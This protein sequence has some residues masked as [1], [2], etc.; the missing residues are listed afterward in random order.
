MN[1]CI[2]S[3]NSY[4]FPNKLIFYAISG[5]ILVTRWIT[6]TLLIKTLKK[7]ITLSVHFLSSQNSK[8]SELISSLYE[9]ECELFKPLCTNIQTS[10][11]VLWLYT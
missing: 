11:L 2:S 10:D 9:E 6:N 7:S 3:Q 5:V 4:Q 1:I 8:Q